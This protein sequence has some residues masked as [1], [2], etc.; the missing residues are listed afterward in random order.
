MFGDHNAVRNIPCVRCLDERELTLSTWLLIQVGGLQDTHDSTDPGWR[1]QSR[2]A[3]ALAPV[4]DE[5]GSR[6][7]CQSEVSRRFVAKT[8]QVGDR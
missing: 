1:Q 8:K 3:E 2:L 4:D 7:T 6:A 5:F